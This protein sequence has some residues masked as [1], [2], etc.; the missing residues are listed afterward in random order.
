M[1]HVTRRAPESGPR[2]RTRRA[3]LDAAIDV[4]A[5]SR[6][7]SLSEVAD[8]AGVGRSTLHR[9]FPDRAAL[10]DAMQEDAI[11][12]TGRVFAEAA[13]DQG[14]PSEALHRLVEAYFGLA[15]RMMFLFTEIPDDG[16]WDNESLE[17][18]HMPVAELFVRG[19]AA[20][21]FDADLSI[22]W[23]IRALWSLVMAGWEAV[24]EGT[25]RKHEAIANVIRM[26]ESGISAR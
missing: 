16:G 9:H 6:G 18:T 21:V 1:I 25:M 5:G 24:T 13:L 10:I 4:Y 2:S 11:A 12:A 3:I 20:D 14:T 26:L 15:P 22:D 23:L 7:A 19:Q 17:R 8:A